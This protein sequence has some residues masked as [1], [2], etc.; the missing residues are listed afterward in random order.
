[1]QRVLCEEEGKMSEDKKEKEKAK[2]ENPQAEPEERLH[3][4]EDKDLVKKAND[5][6]Q[7]L[8]KAN[9]ELGRLLLRKETS[10]DEAILAGEAIAGERRE[11]PEEKQIASAKQLLEGSGYEDLFDEPKPT[12]FTRK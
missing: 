1:M 5:A 8:E 10:N 4:T 3:P 12:K 7:R 11:T 9:I 6:A 2:E